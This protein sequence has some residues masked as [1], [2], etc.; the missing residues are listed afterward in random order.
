M[1]AKSLISDILHV[2]GFEAWL[3]NQMSGSPP[4]RSHSE[5]SAVF[6]CGAGIGGFAFS[7]I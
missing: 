3:Y 4:P 2:N 1:H 6:E 5:G 7:V